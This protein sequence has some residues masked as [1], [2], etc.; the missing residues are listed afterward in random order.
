MRENKLSDVILSLK[1]QRSEDLPKDRDHLRRLL[2]SDF[3]ARNQGHFHFQRMCLLRS[4]RST[5]LP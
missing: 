4:L 5:Q 1:A 2:M 3:V